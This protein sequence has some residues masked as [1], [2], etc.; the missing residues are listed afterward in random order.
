MKIKAFLTILSATVLFF[1]SHT[2]AEYFEKPESSPVLMH[3]AGSLRIGGE[4]ARPGDEIG[5]FDKRGNIV[6]MF[7]IEKDGIFGDIAISGDYELTDKIEGASE[8]GRL[9]IR[10]WQKSTNIEYS[11]GSIYLHQPVESKAVYESYSEP[12]LQF[13]GG[14]FY[15]LDIEVVD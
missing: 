14:S 1:A 7:V 15:L 5:I 3:L 6:G 4:V 2:S 11:G 9:E 13:K 12:M 8:V 10:V